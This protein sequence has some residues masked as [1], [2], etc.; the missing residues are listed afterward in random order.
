MKTPIAFLLIPL[1][2]TACMQNT[3]PDR[4]IY[5]TPEMNEL[6]AVRPYPYTYD[7]CQVLT[8]NEATQ[9][10]TISENHKLIGCPSHETGAINDRIKMNGGTVLGQVQKWTILE[11]SR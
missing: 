9:A 5:T 7:V 3:P 4:A 2:L 11:V 1:A 10:F 8:P 6:D